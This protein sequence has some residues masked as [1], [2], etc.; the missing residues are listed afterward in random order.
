M[1][2]MI[3][4]P[5]RVPAGKTKFVRLHETYMFA[6]RKG[7]ELTYMVNR[8]FLGAV[9]STPSVTGSQTVT[10]RVPVSYVSPSMSGR[11]RYMLHY[12]GFVLRIGCYSFSPSATRVIRGWAVKYL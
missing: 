11:Q 1:S 4:I 2:G 5:K 8:Q 7:S 9:L 10:V 12:D 3:L 6:G